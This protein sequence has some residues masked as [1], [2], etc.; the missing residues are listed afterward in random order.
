M[1][2]SS[3]HR[4]A[5]IEN[6]F[7]ALKTVIKSIREE[8][9]NINEKCKESKDVLFLCTFIKPEVPIPIKMFESAF[10]NVRNY[11]AIL[12][13][14]NII[15]IQPHLDCFHVYSLIQTIL[16]DIQL[17]NGDENKNDK[18]RVMI[19]KLNELFYNVAAVYNSDDDDTLKTFEYVIPHIEFLMEQ[20]NLYEYPVERDY[21]IP[22]ILHKLGIYYSLHLYDGDKC[23]HYCDRALKL[24]YQQNKILVSEIPDAKKDTIGQ[25]DTAH[26]LDAM[27]SACQLLYRFFDEKVHLFKTAGINISRIDDIGFQPL[28]IAASKGNIGVISILLERG[29]DVNMPISESDGTRAVHY[30][31]ANGH[32]DIVNLLIQV[33]N[34]T[35]A[36]DKNG[37]TALHY[38]ISNGHADVVKALAKADGCD[39]N[40]ADNNGQAPLHWSV[41]TGNLDIVTL[42][43]S[44]NCCTDVADNNG[45]QPL[46]LA[47]KMKNPTIA[48]LLI[49]SHCDINACN[50][51]GQQALHIVANNGDVAIA[52]LLINA[53]C[54][55]T[56]HDKLGNAPLHIAASAGNEAMVSLLLKSGCSMTNGT[57]VKMTSK[58]MDNL[59]P[60]MLSKVTC[61]SDFKNIDNLSNKGKE[62]IKK[63]IYFHQQ[64]LEHCNDDI[65]TR[66]KIYSNIGLAYNEIGQPNKAEEYYFKG[67]NLLLQNAQVHSPHMAIAKCCNKIGNFF[68]SNGQFEHAQKYLTLAFEEYEALKKPNLEM[69]FLILIFFY[70]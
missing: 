58:K 36:R 53:N 34:S 60:F 25:M 31:A 15:A 8:L 9:N 69:V 40:V 35:N 45:E 27:G 26:L 64:A 33:S 47:C 11:L 62:L 4:D 22:L 28:H 70:I 1:D 39:I 52:T 24:K 5:S 14:Y 54:E 48:S 44:S 66:V 38:A 6:S 17:E 49:K 12:Q 23:Y 21:K 32:L 55:K 13:Q 10:Y 18:S 63:A 68:F 42:L 56:K 46:H 50:K 3:S 2:N 59:R 16:K 65:E 57:T 37:V 43:L 29:C 20:W 51:I 61:G 7:L 19:G 30:A 67:L 41:K